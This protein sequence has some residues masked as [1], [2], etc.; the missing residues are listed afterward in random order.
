M[1]ASAR[2][3]IWLPGDGEDRAGRRAQRKKIRGAKKRE[4][5]VTEVKEGR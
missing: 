3:L 1:F 4:R 5:K 2:Y